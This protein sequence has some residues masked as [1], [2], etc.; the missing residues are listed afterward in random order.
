MGQPAVVLSVLLCFFMLPFI[1]LSS[2]P[3]ATRAGAVGMT[4]YYSRNGLQ[5][6]QVWKSPNVARLLM[7]FYFYSSKWL[8]KKSY[9]WGS[10]VA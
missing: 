8:F 5:G 6:L 10:W 2:P 9:V 1:N 3:E 4:P 7:R